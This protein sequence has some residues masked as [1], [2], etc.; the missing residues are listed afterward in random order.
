MRF[1]CVLCGELTGRSATLPYDFG[2]SL[3]R[4]SIERG[5]SGELHCGECGT[6][7][8]AMPIHRGCEYGGE[9]RAPFPRC[10]CGVLMTPEIA[11]RA[12]EMAD[13]PEVT[14]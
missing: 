12:A 1:P 13:A 8:Q 9:E 7:V 4:A 14:P 2:G 5:I 6:R 10:R 3:W 11:T